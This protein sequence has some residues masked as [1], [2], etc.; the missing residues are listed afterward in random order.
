MISLYITKHVTIVRLWPKLSSTS[1]SSTYSPLSHLALPQGSLM[2]WLISKTLGY[3]YL[4]DNSRIE[5][6]PF[7]NPQ[8]KTLFRISSN[9]AHPIT[10]PSVPS[11][12]IRKKVTTLSPLKFSIPRSSL[13]SHWKNSTIIHSVT[14]IALNQL[15]VFHNSF[16]KR[17]N[18][19]L[20]CA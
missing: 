9:V 16:V 1:I 3:E 20:S 7:L 17:W 2:T 13:T 11:I 18:P 8:P 4:S 12:S 14:F 15:R 10:Q 6:T 5:A 19:F